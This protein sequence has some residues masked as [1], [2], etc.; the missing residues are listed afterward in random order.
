M[1]GLLQGSGQIKAGVMPYLVDA[2]LPLVALGNIVD[3]ALIGDVGDTLAAI[4][5]L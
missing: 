5:F 1:G 4:I 2:L 3:L